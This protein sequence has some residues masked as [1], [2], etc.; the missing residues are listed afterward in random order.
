VRLVDADARALG[1]GVGGVRD[2]GC[3]ERVRDLLRWQRAADTDEEK[4]EEWEKATGHVSL[5]GIPQDNH[6]DRASPVVGS[7]RGAH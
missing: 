7:V 2:G 3:E 4:W 5:A 1:H 6:P